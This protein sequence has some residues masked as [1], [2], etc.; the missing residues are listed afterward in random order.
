MSSSVS[1]HCQTCRP[2]R[3]VLKHVSS[4]C[5]RP[6]NMH[7]CPRLD[8]LVL[9]AHSKDWFLIPD[10]SYPGPSSI[11][12]ASAVRSQSLRT[13]FFMYLYEYNSLHGNW[14]KTPDPTTRKTEFTSNNHGHAIIIS[15]R[16]T[17]KYKSVHISGRASR[18]PCVYLHSN[19]WISGRIHFERREDDRGECRYYQ[20]Q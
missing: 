10:S 16:N 14:K 15:K 9:I 8:R 2:N 3:L 7:Y 1:F 12:S 18:T 19:G 6:S 4:L 5:C 11:S 20:M 13:L 17:K